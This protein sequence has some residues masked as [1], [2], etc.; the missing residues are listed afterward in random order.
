MKRIRIP[1]VGRKLAYY[2]WFRL[3]PSE[4]IRTA[5]L[6]F[7][8]A[9]RQGNDGHGDPAAVGS[10]E[11]SFGQPIVVVNKPGAS[12][13]LCANFVANSKPTAI[14]RAFSASAVIQVPICAK[15]PTTR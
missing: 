2:S 6:P 3:W 15:F 4:H 8:A 9:L 12:H 10:G 5:R 14:P 13:T 7:T 11:Q 1:V